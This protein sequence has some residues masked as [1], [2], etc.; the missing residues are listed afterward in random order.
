MLCLR[1]FTKVPST[2]LNNFCQPIILTKT[3]KYT[4]F[5]PHPNLPSSPNHLPSSTTQNIHLTY[6]FV[7]N[8][9]HTTAGVTGRCNCRNLVPSELEAVSVGQVLIG[10]SSASGGN[11]TLHIRQQLFQVTSAGNV[12]SMHMRVHYTCQKTTTLHIR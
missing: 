3:L 5:L 12:V 7:V 9:A 4:H 2:P 8:K 6:L 10:S 11:D 1:N